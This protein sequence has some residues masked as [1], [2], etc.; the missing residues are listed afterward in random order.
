[1]SSITPHEILE[2]SKQAHRLDKSFEK[3]SVQ[4]CR[5]DAT[6]NTNYDVGYKFRTL[7]YDSEPRV[8]VDTDLQ[9]ERKSTSVSKNRYTRAV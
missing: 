6:S 9:R 7:L 5:F 1:M 8:A 4:V 2:Q 3:H